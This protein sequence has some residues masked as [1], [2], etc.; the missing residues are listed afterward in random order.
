M[1]F[2]QTQG[3]SMPKLGLGTFRMT[4]DQCR[5][6]V[7]HALQIGYRHIDTAEMYGNEAPIGQAI[8]AAGLDR[9]SL[10]VT[11]KVWHEHLAPDQIRSAFKASLDRLRLDF[12]DLYLIHWPSPVMDLPGALETLMHLREQGFARAIGVSNFNLP[13]IKAAVEDVRAPI[14]C[15]QVEYHVFLDQTPMLDYLRRK[16]IP[17][18]A[19]APLAKGATAQNDALNRIGKKYGISGA[20]VALAWLLGQDGVGAIPKAQSPASQAANLKAA[21]IVLDDDDR[22]V[23]A[24]LPKNLRNVK[25][26]FAPDWDAPLR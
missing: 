25:P 24:S 20:Q 7:E 21:E 11:T 5:A 9:K 8:A 19:Y 18:I 16:G 1:K 10:F 23:I 4:D 2:L 6:A 17:L 26:A 12:V 14:A 22:R 13:L 3:V 15:N